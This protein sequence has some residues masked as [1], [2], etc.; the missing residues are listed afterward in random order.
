M[1]IPPATDCR[2]TSES[3]LTVQDWTRSRPIKFFRSTGQIVTRQIGEH[4]NVFL[5]A[6]R[7]PYNRYKLPIPS[8]YLPRYTRHKNT[9]RSEHIPRWTP[10]TPSVRR[11]FQLVEPL[12][13]ADRTS[14]ESPHRVIQHTADNLTRALYG[15]M[16][17]GPTGWKPIVRRPNRRCVRSVGARVGS[18]QPPP[19][20][21]AGR[22]P[23]KASCRSLRPWRPSAASGTPRCRRP[24]AGPGRTSTVRG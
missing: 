4:L 6:N 9:S 21:E 12:L 18:R 23:W 16:A 1:A 5:T 20:N 8:F 14:P 7:R 11:V 2:W 24:P 19:R 22:R 15:P 10:T 3:V 13:P 17:L